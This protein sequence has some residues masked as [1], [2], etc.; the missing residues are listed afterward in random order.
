MKQF[1]PHKTFMKQLKPQFG[2]ESHG[3]TK[4][5]EKIENTSKLCKTI[6]T[7]SNL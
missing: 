5:Y 3:T 6:K 1:K 7:T 4:N 2:F